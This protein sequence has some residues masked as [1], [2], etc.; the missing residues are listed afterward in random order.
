MGKK[1]SGL[2][3]ALIRDRFKTSQSIVN[4]DGS[5]RHSKQEDHVNMQSVTQENDL[6]AF[7]NT[8]T[9]AGT[10]FTARFLFLM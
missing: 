1:K 3:K 7:L 6:E 8:A 10:E 4:F 5:L 9:L 2:G